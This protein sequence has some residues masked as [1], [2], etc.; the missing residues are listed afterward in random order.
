MQGAQGEGRL[1]GH[2][3]LGEGESALVSRLNLK[4]FHT[5]RITLLIAAIGIAM[6]ARA[7]HAADRPKEDLWPR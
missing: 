7:A 6:A 1:G 2:S 4:Y 5:A 3:D